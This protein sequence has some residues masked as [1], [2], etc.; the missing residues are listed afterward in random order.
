MEAQVGTAG[1]YN[2]I[3]RHGRCEPGWKVNLTLECSSSMHDI[4]EMR[5]VACRCRQQEELHLVEQIS[6]RA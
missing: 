1:T 5:I 2:R 3:T 4:V 6:G